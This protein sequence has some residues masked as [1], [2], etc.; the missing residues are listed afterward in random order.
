[1]TSLIVLLL[2]GL[3]AGWLAGEI[4]K[5]KRGLVGNLVI[6]VVGAFI[7]G[8]LAKVVGLAATGLIGSIILATIGAVVLL[9]VLN[10]MGS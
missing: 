4:M 8:F 10:R 3:V 6:G 1:M 7:G 9:W 5:S 2:V